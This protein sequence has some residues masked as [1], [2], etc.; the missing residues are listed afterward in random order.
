MKLCI[1]MWYDSNISSYGDINYKINKEYCYKNNINLICSNEK[2]YNNRPQTWE[3]IP[4]ILEH[5]ND[6]DYVMWMD[7]DSHFYIDSKNI[8]DFINVNN[9]YNFIFSNDFVEGINAGIFIVKNSQY[10][11]DFLKKWGYDDL[12]YENRSL[13]VWEDQSVLLDMHSAN[14]L[15]I[16][17]NSIIIDYGVLQHF[18]DYELGKY[19]EKPFII[20]L[21]GQTLENRYNHSLDYFNKMYWMYFS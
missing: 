16:K 6:Y 12:L 15:D 11:I 20:H 1:L 2:K 10:S 18:Y 3:R 13:R 7:A 19:S 17:N 21:A 14:I 8:I 9:K 5:I 4:L